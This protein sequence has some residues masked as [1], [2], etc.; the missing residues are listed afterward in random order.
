MIYQVGGI[1]NVY[2]ISCLLWI[3]FLTLIYTTDTETDRNRLRSQG[4]RTLQVVPTTLIICLQSPFACL[5]PVPNRKHL[6]GPSNLE[7]FPSQDNHQES[8]LMVR[9]SWVT[10]HWRCQKF[11]LSK[12]GVQVGVHAVS[13]AY[14][15]VECWDWFTPKSA[16]CVLPHSKQVG[17]TAY[18]NYQPWSMSYDY[19]L[20]CNEDGEG[21]K[22]I[23]SDTH[24]FL[25]SLAIPF[26]WLDFLDWGQSDV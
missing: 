17:F 5:F 14:E 8:K 7:R 23:T 24:F 13:C 25:R 4:H 11:K 20:E 15:R 12:V 2:F 10:P 9:W 19:S 21:D 16:F 6:I 1:I 26:R 22:G 18:D 3:F